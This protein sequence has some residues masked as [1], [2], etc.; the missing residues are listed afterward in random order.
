MLSIMAVMLHDMPGDTSPSGSL[1]NLHHGNGTR[2]SYVQKDSPG[3]DK[4]ANWLPSP[5]GD[6]GLLMRLYWLNENELFHSWDQAEGEIA[7]ERD[8]LYRAR[9]PV[10]R[11]YRETTCQRA[12]SSLP[13]G[14]KK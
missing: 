2:M 12:R 11:R 3:K 8:G 1:R 10:T 13:S 4:E 6:F 9:G 7:K 14:S 5:D